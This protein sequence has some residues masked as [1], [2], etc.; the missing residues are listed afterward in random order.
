MDP[1]FKK[2]DWLE[3]FSL[4]QSDFSMLQSN[5]ESKMPTE[6]KLLSS[7]EIIKMASSRYIK[8]FDCG[9]LDSFFDILSVAPEDQQSVESVHLL[10]TCAEMMRNKQ[11][12]QA[13]RVLMSCRT[14]SLQW[15]NPI[16]RLCYYFSGALEDRIER[17]TRY[18]LS[19]FL[20]D[21]IVPTYNFQAGYNKTELNDLGAF[22]TNIIPYVRLLQFTSVQAI[23]D[24]ARNDSKIHLIDL[25]IRNG[26]QWSVLMQSL[27]LRSSSYPIKLLRITAVGKDIENL[28]EG[29]R[30]LHEVAQSLKI[31]FIYRMVEI[32]SMEEIQQGMF[33]VK[34]GEVVAVYAPYAFSS[35]LYKRNLLD[36]LVDVI[37]KLRPRIMVN[38]EVEADHNSP[39]FE[40]R[41]VE[42][43]FFCSTWFDYLDVILPDRHDTR[44]VMYEEV[45]CGKTLR[46]LVACEMNDRRVRHVKTDVWRCYFGQK[47][48]KEMSFS[49]QAWYQAR[50]LL[51]EFP[52]GECY[53]LDANGS[54]I[55]MGWKGT[56]L[57]TVSAWTCL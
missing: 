48:L 34:P 42:V 18:E 15:G 13:A 20:K 22:A 33:N 40:N 53:S 43:L 32:S 28:I 3:E 47:G 17:E 14:F 55:T 30:R 56:Q 27:A 1:D 49:Y 52:H 2:S 6:T 35:L 45:F 10:F 41:F 23:L 8:V 7:Q 19:N 29:G 16:Q 25:E 21:V 50:L 26:S 4:P 38:I 36:N 9:G 39:R 5:F 37:V 46:N 12:D 44:R 51:K 24:A 54:A 11:Y 31:P 57:L